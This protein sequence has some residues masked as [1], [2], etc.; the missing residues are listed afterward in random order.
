[1]NSFNRRRRRRRRRL[2]RPLYRRRP[3]GTRTSRFRRR[4]VVIAIRDCVER[5]AVTSHREIVNQVPSG[6][7]PVDG[8][9]LS[10]GGF[11]HDDR[12]IPVS[13]FNK[14]EGNVGLG[15]G[16]GKELVTFGNKSNLQKTWKKRKCETRKTVDNWVCRE[17]FEF[18]RKDVCLN[19]KIRIVQITNNY[20]TAYNENYSIYKQSRHRW[21]IL[22][23]LK[24]FPI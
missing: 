5:A 12:E 4:V 18:G 19:P 9:W 1:M 8:L 22:A 3:V 7:A 14:E 17:S 21:K 24:A 2:R 23:A 11:D 6:A 13:H 20:E 15:I 10:R 16:F